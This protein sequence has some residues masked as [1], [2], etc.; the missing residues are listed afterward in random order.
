MVGNYEIKYQGCIRLLWREGWCKEVLG[1]SLDPFLQLLCV[2]PVS[3][4]LGVIRILHKHFLGA[5]WT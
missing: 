4:V 5:I 1:V 3:V 2:G